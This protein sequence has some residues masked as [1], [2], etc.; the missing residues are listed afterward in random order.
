MR[1]ALSGTFSY[2]LRLFYITSSLFN[3]L[4]FIAVLLFKNTILHPDYLALYLLSPLC[5]LRIVA[6][7]D[8]TL[9]VCRGGSGFNKYNSPYEVKFGLL[10]LALTNP[11]LNAKRTENAVAVMS[12]HMPI[13]QHPNDVMSRHTQSGCNLE[14]GYGSRKVALNSNP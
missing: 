1:R 12:N 9:S 11:H 5:A 7:L 14:K 13:P 10:P 8:N 6:C 2:S 3:S 4:L